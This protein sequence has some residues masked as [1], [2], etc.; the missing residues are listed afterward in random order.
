M[1]KRLEEFTEHTGVKYRIANVTSME[2]LSARIC[3]GEGAVL[4]FKDK[5]LVTDRV[6]GG[7]IAAV[8]EFIDEP[9]LFS[10][11]ECRIN[12]VEF[13]EEIFE[14]GGSAIAWAMAQ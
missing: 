10:R 14:D 11:Q 3:S 7:Y 13:S 1:I 5:V 6:Y 12:L 8:Y 4:Q 9:N 2:N